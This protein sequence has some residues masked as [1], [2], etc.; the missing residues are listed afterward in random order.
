MGGGAK[1]IASRLGETSP[2]QAFPGQETLYKLIL[3]Q[4]SEE[5]IRIRV[6]EKA[7]PAVVTIKHGDSLGSGFIVTRNGLVLT[8]A[9]VLEDA[10]STV[11]VIL[12]DGRQV[13]ADVIGFQGQGLDLAAVKIRNQNNLPTVKLAKPGSTRVGQSVYAIGFPFGLERTFTSGVVSRIDRKRNWIQHDAAINPGN[14]GGPLLNSKAEVIG[15]NTLLIN[16]NN[17][18]NTGISIAIAVEEVQPF[19]TALIKGDTSL[20]ARQPKSRNNENVAIKELPIDGK[21]VTAKL[22]AG[23]DVL[24]NNTYFQIYAFKGQA[25]Q[26]VTIEMNSKQIDS[27]LFLVSSNQNKL[28]DNNDDISPNNFNARLVVTLPEDGAYYV[29]ANAFEQGESGEYSL[30]ATFK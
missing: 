30:K 24:P 1:V 6:N 5:E 17:E 9:H 21:T 26:Q 12:A 18:S 14:S 22:K 29:I 25:G 3:A 16:P 8:N 27:A 4:S 19:L 2:K 11:T 15:V 13:L 10:P 23:D 7:S 20:I 28:I